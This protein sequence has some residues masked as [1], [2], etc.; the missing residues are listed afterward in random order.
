MKVHRDDLVS[1]QCMVKREAERLSYQRLKDKAMTHLKLKLCGGAEPENAIEKVE[2]KSKQNQRKPAKKRDRKSD[3]EESD[4]KEDKLTLRQKKPKP[5]ELPSPKR[6]N[7]NIYPEGMKLDVVIEKSAEKQQ[8]AE[9]ERDILTKEKPAAI[10]H[11]ASIKI[12]EKPIDAGN[13]SARNSTAID[14]ERGLLH[15]WDIDSDLH[16]DKQ[17]SERERER[18]G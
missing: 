14:G 10:L 3:N 17:C 15:R 11:D 5:K 12:I 16:S 1:L 18:T 4:L 13:S 7:T 8:T 9:E 6:R 2:E